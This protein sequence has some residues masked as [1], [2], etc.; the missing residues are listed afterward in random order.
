[1]S[2]HARIR[3]LCVDDH[4]LPREGIA[5]IINN[6]PDIAEQFFISEEAVK[7]HI[8]TLERASA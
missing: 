3:I 2:C 8:I 6:Q 5:T 1:M 4:P 7:V